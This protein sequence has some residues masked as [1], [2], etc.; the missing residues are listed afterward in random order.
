MTDDQQYRKGF[1]ISALLMGSAFF[2]FGFYSGILDVKLW[3]FI[4]TGIYFFLILLIW[5]TWPLPYILSSFD[6]LM[7]KVSW[8][9]WEELQSSSVVVAI[10]SLIIALI[11]VGMDYVAGINSDESLWRGFLGWFYEIITP[12]QELDPN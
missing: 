7:Y 2:L 10:A 9:T 3:N 11:I 1:L 6:E 4:Y 8:P 5:K 12:N